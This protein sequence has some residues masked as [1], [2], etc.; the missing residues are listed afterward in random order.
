MDH[1]S[2]SVSSAM[3]G[4]GVLVLCTAFLLAGYVAAALRPLGAQVIAAED[5]SAES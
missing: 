3:P 5:A 1:P 4:T 2:T